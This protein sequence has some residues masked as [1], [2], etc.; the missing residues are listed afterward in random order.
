MNRTAGVSLACAACLTLAT[1]YLVT[2]V[3]SRDRL[4]RNAPVAAETGTPTV[5]KLRVL[6]GGAARSSVRVA[7]DGP[8]G[9]TSAGNWRVLA[10]GERLAA[11]QT[12]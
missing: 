3:T 1:V 12:R 8:Y 6:I 2:D 10:Q 4:R 7:V 5:P 11:P 9:I